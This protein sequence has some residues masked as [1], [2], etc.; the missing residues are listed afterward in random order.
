MKRRW[1]VAVLCALTVFGCATIAAYATGSPGNGEAY[2]GAPKTVYVKSDGSD[3][4]GDGSQD[5][6]YASLA[7]AVDTAEDG[8]T[9]YVLSNLTLT[10]SA[11]FWG[12]NLTIT[13]DENGPYTVTRGENVDTVNDSA[14][15][16]YNGAM[17]EVGGNPSLGKTASLTLKNIVFD[18]QGSKKG[19]YF[20]QADSDS[21]GKTSVAG[22]EVNNTDIVQDA[23]VATYN[24][25]A[26]IVLD[27]GT[28]LM[29]FGGMSAVRLSGGRLVMKSGAVICDDAVSDR[30][31][32]NTGSNGP[33]GAIWMQ[34]GTFTM[35]DGATIKNIVG[36]VLYMDSG[37]A[38]LGGEVVDTEHDID[39]WQSSRWD[40][41]G[42]IAHVRNGANLELKA[43]FKGSNKGLSN[44][45]PVVKTIGSA[46][47]LSQDG[48]RLKVHN[49]AAFS[50]YNGGDIIG[51]GAKVDIEFNGEISHCNLGHAITVQSAAYHLVLGPNSNIHHNTVSYGT[52]YSQGVN[53]VVDIYGKINDNVSTDRAGGIAFANNMGPTTATMYEGAEICR[54][55]SYQT[56]GAILLSRAVL[57]IQGGKIVGN[58]SGV[59]TDNDADKVGGGI[60]VRRGGTLIMKGGEIAGNYSCGDGG[61]VALRM[62]DWGTERS[63]GNE[64]GSGIISGNIMHATATKSSDGSYSVSGGESN[65]VSII[66][67]SGANRSRYVV[68]NS[69]GIMENDGIYFSGY[70]CALAGATP[71]TKFGD[72]SQSSVDVLMEELKSKKL[73]TCR[74]A[75]WV[76]GDS[77]PG[78]QNL[79]VS[80]PANFDKSKPAYVAIVDVNGQGTVSANPEIKLYPASFD[81]QDSSLALDV[82]T[83]A[84]NGSIVAIV[85]EGDESATIMSI[86]PVDTIIYRGADDGYEGMVDEDGNIVTNGLFMPEPG[87][88]VSFSNVW[89]DSS[90]SDYYQRLK[91]VTITHGNRSWTLWPY[92]RS[93]NDPGA[94]DNVNAES[95]FMLVAGKGTNQALLRLT[96]EDGSI[97]TDDDF[98]IADALFEQYLIEFYVSEGSPAG[99]KASYAGQGD[100]DIIRFD[101]SGGSGTLEIRN[102]SNP[103]NDAVIS[104]IL[105]EKVNESVPLSRPVTYADADTKYFINGET[106][107]EYQARPSLLFDN[108]I[109]DKGQNRS[110]LLKKR[111]EGELKSP[112]VGVAR[113]F[114]FKYLDLLDAANGNIWITANK[115]L[116]VYWPY[117]SGT[118]QN[119]KFSVYHF[120]GLDRESAGDDV[121]DDVASAEIE[122]LMGNMELT[123]AG[124]KISVKDFSPFA[125]VWETS[126]GETGGDP[127]PV[128]TYYTID[129][130]AGEGGSIT[131]SGKVSVARGSDKTF[132][133]KTDDGYV[134]DDVVVDGKSVGAVASYTFKDVKASHSISVTFREDDRPAN[135]DDT[136][137]SDLLETAKHR[138]FLHGYPRGAFAPDSD[139]TRA[140]V[141]AMFYNLLK[142]KNVKVTETFKDVPQDAWYKE[143]VEVLATLGI[144][145]GYGDTGEYRPERKITRAE[146]TTIAMRF[147]KGEAGGENI[148]SDVVESDWFYNTVVGSVAYGWIHGYDD[149][150]FRPNDSI[151]RAEVTAITDA[152]LG[153][154]ADREFVDAA[155]KKGE[156]KAFTD[157]TSDHWAYYEIMEATN[158]HA[159]VLENGVESWTELNPVE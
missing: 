60:H 128:V 19:E 23:I 101:V 83:N 114:E 64:I 98:Q 24:G 81:E 40:S 74:F 78:I 150:T 106:E 32:G 97:S 149:G 104:D 77:W 18:D 62:E 6:P 102:V 43:S 36:R 7:K 71:G 119:T 75:I 116:S 11:R 69:D 99:V 16:D 155:A 117:P 9:V 30:T 158:A 37:T 159:H 103:D 94:W 70:K 107:I 115:P 76:Q 131:P 21:D 20:V 93:L 45:D 113:H 63:G 47:M 88:K 156:L 44:S 8:S 13:S 5:N 123:A 153:R 29:N 108:I 144:L 141:A 100:G 25:T 89:S 122:N 26:D 10:N 33:A 95:V 48:C 39:M 53:A 85:Q 125:L 143:P 134:I 59:N 127:G 148:F 139:M 145:E 133:I 130:S 68:F 146:F 157:L 91:N 31:R 87:F 79:K 136:G 14:R 57:T 42:Y 111:L 12:K 151:T 147:T 152:M 38:M 56:G 58:I 49:G 142:D 15:G 140:E 96:A 54:N 112:S 65:D 105:N 90:E 126:S 51:T 80:L 92:G 124:I 35:D 4:T 52:I 17:L 2:R 50:H 67:G 28:I 46:I 120:N 86:D 27:K 132:A 138:T 41:Q 73:E 84:T 135:P 1:L 110:E 154:R 129:A 66:N 109:D 22:E 34:G 137:V 55:V 3:E 72:A 82:R 118:D 121:A 61:G